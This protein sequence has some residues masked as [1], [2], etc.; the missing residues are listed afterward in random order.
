LFNFVKTTDTG[1]VV[2][3]GERLELKK[4]RASLTNTN[5]AAELKDDVNEM[6]ECVSP[7]RPNTEGVDTEMICDSNSI[8]GGE[9]FNPPYVSFAII[10]GIMNTGI[11]PQGPPSGVGHVSIDGAMDTRHDI[12]NSRSVLS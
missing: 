11:I 1:K 6:E 12:P 10:P 2:G 8:I 5:E 7:G 3:D 4:V 9:P